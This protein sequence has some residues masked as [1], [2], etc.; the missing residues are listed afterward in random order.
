MDE[1]VSHKL[2]KKLALICVLSTTV[3]ESN[4]SSA[5]IFSDIR[6]SL[7]SRMLN[8]IQTRWEDLHL[9]RFL[10]ELVKPTIF[11]DWINTELYEYKDKDMF[12]TPSFI[13]SVE[14]GIYKYHL[15]PHLKDQHFLYYNLSIDRTMYI[16]QR[17]PQVP[18]FP[19]RYSIYIEENIDDIVAEAIERRK[20]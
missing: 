7:Y 14:D 20:L 12:I 9:Q 6:V 10:P 15:E 17:A 2:L 4:I 11:L 8:S 3:T 13:N 1:T 18:I 5:S 19:C 16:L